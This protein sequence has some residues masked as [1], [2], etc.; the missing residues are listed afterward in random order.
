MYKHYK[1]LCR[2]PHR[3]ALHTY[4]NASNQLGMIIFA[5]VLLRCPT[6][7]SSNGCQV[8]F[9]LERIKLSPPCCVL[10]YCFRHF[11]IW[12][13]FTRSA[14]ARW[15]C[16]SWWPKLPAAGTAKWLWS[17]GTAPAS[18]GERAAVPAPYGHS[19]AIC[20]GVTQQPNRQLLSKQERRLRC[21]SRSQC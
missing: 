10:I 9:G 1:T 21:C 20:R 18:P 19:Q 5:P 13:I 7:Y 11:H 16:A 4:C 3:I 17:W 15:S 2:F 14:T 6:S 12:L 8:L